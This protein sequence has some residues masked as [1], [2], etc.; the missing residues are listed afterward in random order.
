MAKMRYAATLGLDHDPRLE[1]NYSA[2]HLY[3]QLPTSATKATFRDE[4]VSG[5]TV[6]VEGRKLDFTQG[7]ATSG[8][9]DTITFWSSG[10]DML[11]RI[12]D[13]E[14]KASEIRVNWPGMGSVEGLLELALAKADVITGSWTGDHLVGADGNDTIRGFGGND[15][16][17]GGR[18][19]DILFG[20]KGEDTFEFTGASFR[21]VIKD[22]NVGNNARHDT[23]YIRDAEFSL[24]R[25]GKKNTVIEFEDGSSVLLEGVKYSE[26]KDIH[27]DLDM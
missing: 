16:I 10:G 11:A 4:D 2:S 25:D 18:G 19:K 13:L 6:V 24:V 1:D 22:F 21:D 5:Y 27:F 15:W 8:T 7:E 14:L 20:G 17:V 3:L 9:I 12:T 26:R 23:I